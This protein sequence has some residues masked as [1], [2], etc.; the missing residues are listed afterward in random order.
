MTLAWEDITVVAGQIT[1]IP[2][3]CC[4]TTTTV[5]RGDLEHG[6]TWIGFYDVR[7][8]DGHS[9]VFPIFQVYT[10]DWSQGAPKESRWC[11]GAD[12]NA[13]LGGFML[14]DTSEDVFHIDAT[15][16]DRSD[17]LGSPFAAEVFAMLDAIIMKDSRLQEI[18][19]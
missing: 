18:S 4:N 13:A 7:F 11:F 5:L 14:R 10:G 2:C 15:T 19:Q 3:D 1:R 16:L 6:A 17:I 8:T 9:D 12:F